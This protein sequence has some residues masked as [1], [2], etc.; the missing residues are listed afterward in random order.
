MDDKA[1]LI[2]QA[3]SELGWT[4]DITLLTQRIQQIN[5]GLVQED[6]FIY[7]LNWTGKCSLIHKIDQFQ[8]P[9]DSKGEY[10]IPDLFVLFNLNGIIKPFFIEIKTT[11]KNRLSWTE[12]YFRGL[13]NYGVK[14]GIPVLIAWKWKSFDI[15][16]L[17]DINHFTKGP[18]NFKISVS[19]AHQENLM[20]EYAGDYAIIINSDNL[21]VF[22]FKKEN[23][24]N[25]R[26]ESTTWQAVLVSI[27]MEDKAGQQ[28]NIN[29]EL[30]KYFLSL[31]TEQLK[32]EET[33]EYIF[34]KF[35]MTSEISFAQHVPVRLK[36]NSDEHEVNWIEKVKTKEYS[37]DYNELLKAVQAG[38]HEG[39]IK[40]V[41]T[42]KPST[43]FD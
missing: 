30:F 40:E 33:N 22:K 18:S 29:N 13:V 35:R 16:T 2:Q 42:L 24:V 28:I 38:C 41:F 31:Q 8:M 7:I 6:E 15:W 12:K 4:A 36:K 39:S 34:Q 14:A 26:K 21:L 9:L 43:N 23:I 27:Y 32:V 17:F 5:G 3:V 19:K 25:R 11:E 20:S 37:I 10:T 1:R